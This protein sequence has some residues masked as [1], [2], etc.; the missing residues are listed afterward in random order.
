MPNLFQAWHS[1]LSDMLI[2]DHHEGC[3]ALPETSRFPSL[4]TAF[5]HAAMPPVMPLPPPPSAAAAQWAQHAY[6][7]STQAAA[8][9]AAAAKAAEVASAQAAAA[10]AAATQ[11]QVAQ[12]SA[13]QAAAAQVAQSLGYNVAPVGVPSAA[14]YGDVPG[15]G[16]PYGAAPGAPR[17][18]D[19]G[20]LAAFA[21]VAFTPLTSWKSP[22]RRLRECR[23]MPRSSSPFDEY[24]R[25]KGR[26]SRIL[27][28][29]RALL[30]GQHFLVTV[31]QNQ[32]DI[33]DVSMVND[34]AACAPRD[35]DLASA[36]TPAAR[37][38]RE[39]CR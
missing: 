14:A 20:P 32:L 23:S 5:A 39:K 2:Q 11:A 16:P 6:T 3:C 18:L 35:S 26:Q 27:L 36:D 12:V 33:G 8:A 24:A 37:Q 15:G 28:S 38:N 29:S 9:K 7:A 13:Q 34:T 4:R 21:T 30:D 22:A 17:L 19:V 10:Q 1:G 25:R 31:P